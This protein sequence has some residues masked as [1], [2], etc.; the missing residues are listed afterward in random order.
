V[1][2]TVHTG[3]ESQTDGGSAGTR[4]VPALLVILVRGSVLLSFGKSVTDQI[5]ARFVFGIAMTA[6]IRSRREPVLDGS[7]DKRW[8]IYIYIYVAWKW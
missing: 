8:L 2:Q 6:Y 4:L 1:L 7:T 5:N 3:I